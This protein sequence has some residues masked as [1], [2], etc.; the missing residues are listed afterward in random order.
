[1]P[2]GDSSSDAVLLSEYLRPVYR[3]RWR[4]LGVG[5]GCGILL[6]LGSFLVPPS[7]L[8][9]STLIPVGSTDKQS[10]LG[11][12]STGLEDLG[13]QPTSRTNP[14]AM[15]PEIV[16]S[17]RLLEKALK[18]PC[19]PSV[20]ARRRPLIEVL[21]GPDRDRRSWEKA[22]KGMRRAVSASLD[23]RTGVLTIEANAK[24]PEVAAYVANT[25]D[26]LLQD[27]TIQ[28]F[29]TQAGANRIFIEGR[30]SETEGSLHT[31]EENL[32]NFREKN[33]RIGNS[34]QLLMEETRYVRLLRAE[35]EVFVTLRRQYEVAKI[36]EHKELPVL[37]VL[38]PAV[39][40]LFRNSP[41][42]GLMGAAGFIAGLACASWLAMLRTR[43]PVEP[44]ARVH[45][46][47]ASPSVPAVPV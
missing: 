22:L 14:P 24:R 13:I 7:Y 36:Q 32:R 29:T 39:P 23:R 27:F 40:P 3:D 8:A 5:L 2:K 20:D 30:L 33:L 10:L 26:T 21:S 1:M 47:S 46:N 41:K 31:A 28:A 11:Q 42:R 35:E 12:L 44:E 25:L 18:T 38:D 4:V 34:P 16:R 43:R 19:P 15:Y 17:R 45:R 37:N 6:Y 9:T